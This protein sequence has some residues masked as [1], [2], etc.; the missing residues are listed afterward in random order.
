NNQILVYRNQNL[1]ALSF[2]QGNF[3]ITE[4][5]K[6]IVSSPLFDLSSGALAASVSRS[7]DLAFALAA[8]EGTTQLSWLDHTG[9]V[10]GT[11]GHQRLAI[12]GLVMSPQDTRFAALMF[13]RTGAEIWIG[14]TKREILTRLTRGGWDATYPVWSPDGSRIAFAGQLEGTVSTYVQTADGSSPE[15]VLVTA[16]DRVFLPTAWSSDGKYLF[17][18]SNQRS[19]H[20][21]IWMYDFSEKK[22]RPILSDLSASVNSGILS[23]DGH[24]LAYVSDESGNR[25]ILV[26]PFPALDRKWQLSTS[27]GSAP[28]WRN[29]GREIIFIAT[30]QSI[31]SVKI[32]VNG[33][34]LEAASP[35]LLFASKQPMMAMAPSPDHKRF[36]AAVLPSDVR[37]EPIHLILNWKH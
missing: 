11:I 5:A 7:G 10:I 34:N 13:G 29:D 20:R 3:K 8:S 31:Q 28:H 23:P 24:W 21:E 33:N 19:I 4:E 6:E 25:E 22:V 15:Q 2:D 36:L 27:G 9:N 32:D 16:K 17:M 14:D 30:D 37:A 18:D 35:V 12:N 1:F 26:R